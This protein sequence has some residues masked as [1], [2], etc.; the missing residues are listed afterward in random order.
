[1]DGGVMVNADE[2]GKEKDIVVDDAARAQTI[3]V[4]AV[5]VVGTSRCRRPKR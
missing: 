2:E 3:V 5:V 1:M 4:A